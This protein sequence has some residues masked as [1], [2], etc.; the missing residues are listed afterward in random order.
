MLWDHL[1]QAVHDQKPSTV[2]ELKQFCKEEWGKKK[3]K[4]QKDGKYFFTVQF[5]TDLQTKSSYV[6]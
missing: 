6:F 4:N 5:E 3:K 2:T 1:K